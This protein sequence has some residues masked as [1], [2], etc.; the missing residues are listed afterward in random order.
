MVTSRPWAAASRFGVL[1]AVVVGLAMLRVPR[2]PTL[3]LLRET[4]GIPCPMCG[5]TTA[6]VHLGRADLAGAV[7]ASPL[8]VA[9]CVGFVLIPFARRSRLATLWRELPNRWRQFIPAFAI[10]AVLAF[11]EIWQIYRFGIL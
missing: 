3:C 4:T 6:A 11:A 10:L 1:I 7:G 9:A 2:P 5:F 8:A